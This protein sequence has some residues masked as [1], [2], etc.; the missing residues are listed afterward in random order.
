[1][2]STTSPAR[3]ACT[4]C[5]SPTANGTTLCKI[6]TAY[7]AD[8]LE[9]CAEHL[10]D[11]LVTS[12]VRTDRIGLGGPRGRGEVPLPWAEAAARALRRLNATLSAWCADLGAE[13]GPEP[14]R[15]V[16]EQSRWL[17][18]SISALRAHPLSGQAFSEIVDAVHAGRCAVDLP[19]TSSRFDVGPCPEDVTDPLRPERQVPCPGTVRASIGAGDRPSIMSC[20]ACPAAWGATE[21]LRTGRRI[22]ARMGS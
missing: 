2:P 9:W 3:T 7:L 4:A 10:A 14:P 6:D 18:R 22:L 20:S 19:P 8:E 1:M 11:E 13:S 21:W 5:G 17:R 12:L 15:G 16:S